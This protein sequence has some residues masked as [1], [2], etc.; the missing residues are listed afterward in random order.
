MNRVISLHLYKYKFSQKADKCNNISSSALAKICGLKNNF[1]NGIPVGKRPW[2]KKHCLNAFVIAKI[3]FSTWSSM[4]RILRVL[5]SWTEEGTNMS[6]LHVKI[7]CNY[8]MRA[9]FLRI[10]KVGMSLSRRSIIGESFLLHFISIHLTAFPRNMTSLL[11]ILFSLGI[12]NHGSI[13]YFRPRVFQSSDCIPTT[14]ASVEHFL[15]CLLNR[16]NFR[17]AVVLTTEIW[18]KITGGN[19]SGAV[20]SYCSFGQRSA[21]VVMMDNYWICA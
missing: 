21:S 3:R 13:L 15:I 17:K 4:S 11:Y 20:A 5:K 8:T 6:S 7:L 9:Y 1:R 12:P 18:T 2:G 16:H 19:N 10:C 14:W